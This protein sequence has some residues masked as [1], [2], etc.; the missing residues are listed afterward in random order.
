MDMTDFEGNYV[1]SD[2]A[3]RYEVAT[4]YPGGLRALQ[5]SLE[6][7]GGDEVGWDWAYQR[8]AALGRYCHYARWPRSHGVTM[9]TP[10][11]AWPG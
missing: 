3:R 1:P 8:I 6:W 9:L 5:T 2:S 4:L 10:P 7:I 11:I